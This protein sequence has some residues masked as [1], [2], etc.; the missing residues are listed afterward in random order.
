[1]WRDRPGKPDSA[2]DVGAN[3]GSPVYAPVSGTVVKVK[4]Y[5]LYGKWN[6]VEVHIQP[7]GQPTLDVVMIHLDDVSATPGDRVVGG[8]T[9][10]AVVRKL[11][12]AVGSQLRSYTNNAG[13]HTPSR[14]TTPRIPSTRG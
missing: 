1:M 3:P 2:A 4:K 14:S 13:Y 8:V 6:D 12:K 7:T 10:L 11:P 9:Q 5:K